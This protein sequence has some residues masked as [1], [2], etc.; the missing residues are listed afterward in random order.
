MNFAQR[1]CWLSIT[2]DIVLN[3]GG[4]YL[5]FSAFTFRAVSLLASDRASVFFFMVFVFTHYPEVPGLAAWSENY[6]WYSSLPL[7]AVV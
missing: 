2:H 7:G 6:K 4:I 5:V 1:I 3:F